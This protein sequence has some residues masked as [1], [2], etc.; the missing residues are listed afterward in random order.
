MTH[1]LSKAWTISAQDKSKSDDASLSKMT[2]IAESVLSITL[3]L[4][5]NLKK[6]NNT[7]NRT[8]IKVIKVT[9]ASK[10]IETIYLGKTLTTCL[11]HFSQ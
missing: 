5:Q 2:N 6:E 10:F 3:T 9:L 1:T 8:L 7:H 4:I 11:L